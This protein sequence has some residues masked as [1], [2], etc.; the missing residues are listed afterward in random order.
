MKTILF[1]T[2]AIILGIVIGYSTVSIWNSRMNESFSPY[3]SSERVKGSELV[4]TIEDQDNVEKRF[5]EKSG[6]D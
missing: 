2:V 4:P 3:R 5:P 6:E 1:T